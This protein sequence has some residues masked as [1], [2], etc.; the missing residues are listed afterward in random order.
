MS[1]TT[2]HKTIEAQRQARADLKHALNAFFSK[3]PFNVFNVA[4]LIKSGALN[5]LPAMTEAQSRL[6]AIDAHLAKGGKAGDAQD[7]DTPVRKKRSGKPPR[8]NLRV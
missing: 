2:R 5:K 7:S 6:S 8:A 3:L 1:A 4:V